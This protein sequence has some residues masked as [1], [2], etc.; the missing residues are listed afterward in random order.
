MAQGLAV[1]DDEKRGAAQ[2]QLDELLEPL[3]G[4]QR[5]ARQP[6]R[7][8]FFRGRARLV[9]ALREDR[10]LA[11]HGAEELGIRELERAGG[12]ATAEGLG[13]AGHARQRLDH[14]HANN[15]ERDHRKDDHEHEEA[16]AV[17]L[18]DPPL[19]LDQRPCVERDEDHAHGA[20]VAQHR[21]RIDVERVAVHEREP[22]TSR[23]A[24]E[25]R[26]HLGQCLRDHGADVGRRGQDASR[27]GRGRPHPGPRRP[28]FD[29][30]PFEARAGLPWR[31]PAPRPPSSPRP[32]PRLGVPCRRTGAAAPR[33]LEDT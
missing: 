10:D 18:P 4:P 11:G 12:S 5:L 17:V 23:H 3:L 24:V 7:R 15:Q 14:A 31:A 27:R 21:A 20:L 6:Q 19:G 30:E 32:A 13:P 2:P 28:N 9:Q 29:G 33:T 16:E 8:L 22:A 26:H 25:R 1:R